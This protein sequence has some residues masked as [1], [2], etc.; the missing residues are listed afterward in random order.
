MQMVQKSHGSPHLGP[1]RNL[2]LLSLPFIFRCYHQK[3]PYSETPTY[4]EQI[5]SP[6]KEKLAPKQCFSEEN[7][8]I[9][10]WQNA[11]SD[12]SEHGSWILGL[13]LSS[14]NK[15]RRTRERNTCSLEIRTGSPSIIRISNVISCGGECLSVP[16]GKM[17]LYLRF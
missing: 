3:Q 8:P 11:I 1:R 13:T 4:F 14:N 12:P 16:C 7:S 6:E 17:I 2:L 9:H 10:P 15:F 5:S